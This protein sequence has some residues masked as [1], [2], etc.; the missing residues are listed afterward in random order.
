MELGY[1]LQPWLLACS[2]QVAKVDGEMYPLLAS[3]EVAGLPMTILLRGTPL[4][5]IW[6]TAELGYGLPDVVRRPVHVVYSDAPSRFE[7]SLTER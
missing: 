2:T 7:L 3:E 6:K 5:A 1:L 4:A